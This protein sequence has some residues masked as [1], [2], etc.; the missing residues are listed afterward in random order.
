MATNDNYQ[1]GDPD[2]TLASRFQNGI[3]YPRQVLMADDGHDVSKKHP[4]PVTSDLAHMISIRRG[5][6][7]GYSAIQKF[8]RNTGVDIAA[9]EDIWSGGGIYTWVSNAALVEVGSDSASDDIA[10]VGAQAVEIYGLD[11]NYHEQMER[12]EISNVAAI[13]SVGT[14][15][16]LHRVVV[17]Q[18]GSSGH[19]VGTVTVTHM[20]APLAVIAIISPTENQ[21]NMAMYTVPSGKTGYIFSV[22]TAASDNA[23]KAYVD[24]DLR[25]RKYGE[26]FA[27]KYNT[28]LIG[29]GTASSERSFVVPI[30]VPE[31]SDVLMRATTTQNNTTVVGAFDMVLVN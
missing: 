3:Q 2:V 8:G 22:H 23:G 9:A 10:G 7:S 21:T 12:I 27:I 17:V 25:V 29:D 20:D 31:K 30:E 19:N 11:E 15:I 5:E 14:Y 4:L 28:I 18:A 1:N 16:R 6:V 24:V 26:V 13:N